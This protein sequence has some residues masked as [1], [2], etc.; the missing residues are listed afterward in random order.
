MDDNI[1]LYE[2]VCAINGKRYIGITRRGLDIRRN[3]HIWTAHS[4]GG[5]VMGAAIRKYGAEN[6]KFRTLVICPDWDYA[7]ALEVAAI[8]AF[9]PRYNVTIGGDG[10]SGFSHTEEH[11][12]YIS[13]RLKG[14][15]SFLGKKHSPETKEKMRQARLAIW[16]AKPRSKNPP[17]KYKY[18]Y[19]PVTCNRQKKRVVLENTGEVF[20]SVTV[21]A[22]SMRLNRCTVRFICQGKYNSRDG[23]RLK[24]LQD[25]SL[26]EG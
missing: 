23:Y 25:N 16:A 18:R 14:R 1:I 6:F 17:K 4:G 21:A 5:S 15:K 24:Y 10:C 7:K 26:T 3:R 8:A 11:K 20:P 2:S 19:K 13:Q 9:K 22:A 12:A